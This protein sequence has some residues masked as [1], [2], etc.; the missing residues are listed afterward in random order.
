MFDVVYG[1]VLADM[2]DVVYGRVLAD[3]FDIVYG[4]VLADMFDIVL[5]HMLQSDIFNIVGGRVPA[6]K[7][8]VIVVLMNIAGTKAFIVV[9]CVSTVGVLLAIFCLVFN[10]YNRQIK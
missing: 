1:R 6:D 8:N 7:T 10:I 3:I 2:F 9:S 4:R 5:C